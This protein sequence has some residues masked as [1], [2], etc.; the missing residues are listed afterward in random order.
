MDGDTEMLKS[1]LLGPRNSTLVLGAWG[2]HPWR[3]EDIVSAVPKLQLAWSSPGAMST[4]EDAKWI[5]W[6][7]HQF[8][9]IAGKDREI[10]LQE[11]KAALNSFFAETFFTL[12]DPDGGGTV[13]LQE[14][15]EALTLLI[16][17]NPTDKLQ[18]LF[19]V[20]GVGAI[21]VDELRTVLQ[22]C[23]RESA[24]SRPDEK[25]DQLLELLGVRRQDCNRAITFDPERAAALPLGHGEP[26]HQ[27]ATHWLKPPPPTAQPRWCRARPL[28][29]AFSNHRS[30]LLCLAADVGLHMLLFALAAS[31]HRAPGPSVMVAKGCANA[32]T[33]TVALSRQVLMLGR[34]LTWPRATWLAQ[35]RLL[36]QNIHFHQLM[37][38]VV[39]VLSLVHTVAHVVSFALQAQSEASAFRFWELLLTTR[40]GI[41][42][43]HGSASPTAPP[44][45]PSQ[46]FF[47]THLTYLPM[48]ILLILHGP[49]F[50]KWLLVP[51]ILFFLEKI[52][53][54]AVSRMAALCIVEVNLLPSKVTH[55][56]I[57]RPPLFHYRAGDSLY[58]NVPSI[59]LYE[60]Q[61]FT[62][63]SALEQKDT[64]WLHVRSKGQWTDR[65][66]ESFKTSCPMDSGRKQLSR[67]LRMRKSQRKAQGAVA[68][69][70]D[71]TVELTSYGPKGT[72]QQGDLRPGPF[73]ELHMYMTSA[74]GKHD[75]KVISLQMALDLLAEKEKDS[76]T[77]LQTRTQPGRPD[78]SKVLQKVAAEKKGKVQV[79]CGSPALAKVLKG[80]CEQFGL[81]FFQEN[82]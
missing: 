66:Y 5:Q 36:D 39:V 18:F 20:Y 19:Q 23:V 47:W 57:E 35:V 82:F 50:W 46:V 72:P 43:V 12:F 10:N 31:V 44:S 75:L 61:P 34:C 70:R 8:E 9:T 63:S 40:P 52:I 55:L 33:L 42:W 17:G 60:W 37:G 41:S 14:L 1:N 68:F 51:G 74:L 48:W 76:I 69:G 11:F 67:R 71:V 27:I 2:S 45:P 49:I 38:Y 64:I 78:W 62:I 13:T 77:G 80:P 6:V 59:A 73:L 15:L 65:L 25:L 53:G 32:S 22:S 56:L 3:S 28:T 54:L 7:T 79:F 81:K 4:E 26:D 29:S 21:D 16:H 58:L 24:I 30:H